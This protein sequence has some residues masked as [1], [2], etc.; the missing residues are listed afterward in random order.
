MS[1][2][3]YFKFL[4]SLIALDSLVGTFF[5]IYLD[6]LVFNRIYLYAF[7]FVD[8]VF[9][10]TNCFKLRFTQIELVLISILTFH[11]LLGLFVLPFINDFYSPSRALKDCIPAILFI[12]KCVLFRNVYYEE[13]I[14]MHLKDVVYWCSLIV[15]A[16][17]LLMLLLPYSASYV[18][19]NPPVNVLFSSFF[20]TGSWL[21]F[22][23]GVVALV[24]AGKRSLM[25]SLILTG[26]LLAAR[27][28]GGFTTIVMFGVVSG[29]AM[30][31]VDLNTLP[32]VDKFSL[33][34]EAIRETLL[35]NVS[36]QDIYES[37]YL[38]TAGRSGELQAIW[39]FMEPINWLV[40]VG[41]GFSF[42]LF[43]PFD[44]P[45]IISNSHF[46]PLS[47]TYKFGILVGAFFI[48]YVCRDIYWG[49]RHRE[50]FLCSML[51]LFF[52]QSLFSFNLFVEILYPLM[53]AWLA[54]LRRGGAIKSGS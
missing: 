18:G 12:S 20:A 53:V 28:R 11:L 23:L 49:L 47:L 42:E 38:A 41:V 35:E 26:L 30:W 25:I 10:A 14:R 1:S 44:I 8:F 36:E 33:M 21:L 50:F 51:L 52:I 31:V 48:W 2:K 27:R 46:T 24:Y 34:L 3:I 43:R 32:L 39:A 13:R 45:V 5:W 15:F 54:I 9:V 19:L 37:L 16:Q 6:S 40:G 17:L 29:V 22:A 7:I 4:I